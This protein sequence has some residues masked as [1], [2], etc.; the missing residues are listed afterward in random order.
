MQLPDLK[1]PKSNSHTNKSTFYYNKNFRQAEQLQARNHG[2][3]TN[4]ILN[5]E[6]TKHKYELNHCYFQ[7][8]SW[9]KAKTGRTGRA[10]INL[11]NNK[12][13]KG[14]LNRTKREKEA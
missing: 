10:F 14:Y 7:R 5:R 12:K 9:F 11:I 13:K 3:P 1:S 8:N 6:K 2:F 4:L